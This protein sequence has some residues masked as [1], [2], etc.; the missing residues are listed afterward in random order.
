MK[1]HLPQVC[2]W[3]DHFIVAFCWVAEYFVVYPSPRFGITVRNCKG[4]NSYDELSRI[5]KCPIVIK[6]FAIREFLIPSSVY[7]ASALKFAHGSLFRMSELN[8][9]TLVQINSSRPLVNNV[10]FPKFTNMLM[11]NRYTLFIPPH[12]TVEHPNTVFYTVQLQKTNWECHCQGLLITS[13]QCNYL[14]HCSCIIFCKPQ[15]PL[16]FKCGSVWKAFIVVN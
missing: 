3:L 4:I 13:S 7:Q 8:V 1:V 5:I 10:S 14:S 9:V 11:T 6:Y 15:N 12:Q 2:H 16:H